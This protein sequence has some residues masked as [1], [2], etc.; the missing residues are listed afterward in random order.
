[1]AERLMRAE[2]HDPEAAAEAVE[3][4]GGRVVHRFGD[5]IVVSTDEAWDTV[6]RRLPRGFREIE[7]DPASIEREVMSG[8]SE[9]NL[10]AAAF[11]LRQRPEYK[12]AQERRQPDGREWSD[13]ESF[14]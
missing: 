4:A 6:R 10:L 5:L 12:A 9:E 1:M 3:R 7:L 11:W 14:E 2:S 13:P 8:L